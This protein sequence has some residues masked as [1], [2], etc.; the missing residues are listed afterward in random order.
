MRR[1][2]LESAKQDPELAEVFLQY[3]AGNTRRLEHL[4]SHSISVAKFN[5]KTQVDSAVI[6]QT[7]EGKKCKELTKV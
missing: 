5:G 1:K 4:I 7:S 6:K 3:S 2:I